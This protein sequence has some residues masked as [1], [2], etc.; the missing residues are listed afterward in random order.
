MGLTG[1]ALRAC[2]GITPGPRRIYFLATLVVIPGPL[3][4]ALGITFSPVLEALAAVTLA[5]ALGAVAILNLLIISFRFPGSGPRRVLGGMLL[6]LSA[7]ALLFGMTLAV[8]FA[9]GRLTGKPLF[10]GLTIAFMIRFH[11]WMNSAFFSLPAIFAYVLLRPGHPGPAPSPPFSRL[12]ARGSVGGDFFERHDLLDH[13]KAPP[14]GLVDDLNELGGLDFEPRRIHPLIRSFYEQTDRFD[15]LVVPRWSPG[16]RTAARVYKL[17]S[18]RVGQ[19]NF[20]VHAES[21]E[22][23]MD[24]RILPLKDDQDGRRK[25]RAWVRVYA[26]TGSPIYAAAYSAHAYR[27]RVYMNI[28]FPHLMGNMTSLLRLENGTGAS[29]SVEL[30]TLPPPPDQVRMGDEGIYYVTSLP[31]ARLPFD[32]RIRVWTR[33]DPHAPERLNRP[34]QHPR[35]TLVAEHDMWLFGYKFLSLDYFIHRR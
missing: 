31:A 16:F 2:E 35:A 17:F 32:E 10:D 30:S 19:M 12:M 14:R 26:A 27:G 23:L 34:E 1:R 9:L 11:G 15:L 8:L 20:P 3:L 22:D 5:L 25:V 33:E 13:G 18:S 6:G 29:G 7:G 24:S 4:T 21:A 28:A